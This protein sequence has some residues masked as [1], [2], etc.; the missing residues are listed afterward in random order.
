MLK[1]VTDLKSFLA[2]KN[3]NAHRN[4]QQM[5][6]FQIP[7]RHSS[8][9]GLQIPSAKSRISR[10]RGLIG[11]NFLLIMGQQTSLPKGISDKCWDL[12]L[13][14]YSKMRKSQ[15]TRASDIFC[16]QFVIIC[17]LTFL[18]FGTWHFSVDFV[19]SL[20][21]HTECMRNIAIKQYQLTQNLFPCSSSTSLQ[22]GGII[23]SPAYTTNP[24]LEYLH[25]TGWPKM[26]HQSQALANTSNHMLVGSHNLEECCS[27]EVL[28]PLH[29]APLPVQLLPST[30]RTDRRRTSSWGW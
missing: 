5:Q 17:N 21:R 11:Q 10:L 13:V 6:H 30:R 12:G 16:S 4:Y 26:T 3:W 23:T 19:L 25:R 14:N 18:I 24:Y 20:K 27:E 7:V 1:N 2:K 8:A 9:D 29:P 15:P 22:L 28:L